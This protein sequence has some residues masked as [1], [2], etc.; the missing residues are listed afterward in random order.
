MGTS[1]VTSRYHC[2][3]VKKPNARSLG[4]KKNSYIDVGILLFEMPT[5]RFHEIRVLSI[6][7]V[8]ITEVLT[9]LL[10]MH[11]ANHTKLDLIMF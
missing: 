4:E 2:K 9:S 8:E 3:N 11:T 5:C 6:T 10:L 7:I 1:W